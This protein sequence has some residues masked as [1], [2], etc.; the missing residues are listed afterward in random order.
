M[1]TL[2]CCML[3]AAL[4]RAG[5]PD[6]GLMVAVRLADLVTLLRNG[7]LPGRGARSA[8]VIGAARRLQTGEP[9]PA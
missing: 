1:S 6:G 3:P 4:R 8:L 9:D 5:G 7:R 2:F